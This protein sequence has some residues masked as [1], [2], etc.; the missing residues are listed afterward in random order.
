MACTSE[1]N[2]GIMRPDPGVPMQYAR[3]RRM[4]ARNDKTATHSG[5]RELTMEW[6]RIK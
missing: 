5:L 2:Y 3:Q 1:C 4:S 6:H